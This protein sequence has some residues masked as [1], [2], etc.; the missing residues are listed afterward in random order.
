MEGTGR[1]QYGLNRRDAFSFS[2]LALSSSHFLFNSKSPEK[3]PLGW[4]G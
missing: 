1:D 2:T 4:V 3:K